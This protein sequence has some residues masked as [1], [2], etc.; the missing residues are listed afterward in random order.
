MYDV[1]QP[2]D[3]VWT[4]CSWWWVL[5]VANY[6][7][8]ILSPTTVSTFESINDA[9]WWLIICDS[10]MVNNRD[11]DG[12]ILVVHGNCSLLAIINSNNGWLD[13]DDAGLPTGTLPTFAGRRN[14]W[15]NGEVTRID[16]CWCLDCS[17][18]HHAYCWYEYVITISTN[19]YYC[20]FFS[21]Y[22][23]IFLFTLMWELVSIDV[24]CLSNW[25]FSRGLDLYSWPR[26]RHH[27]HHTH[28]TWE[29]GLVWGV[30]QGNEQFVHLDASDTTT[31]DAFVF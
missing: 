8:L 2:P 27:V 13:D 30:D 7:L 16:G 11:R 3:D 1:Q 24:T 22:F 6:H 5:V 15:G 9:L 21:T 19:I 4:R 26:R 18:Q 31:C 28:W 20:N 12:W 17:H 14:M 29:G 25:L 10:M 23:N